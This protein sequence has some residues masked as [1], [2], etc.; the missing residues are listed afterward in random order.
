MRSRILIGALLLVGLSSAGVLANRATN[1]EWTIIN[2][3]DPVVV[4]DSLVMGPV[5]IVHDDLKMAQ[6][7]PC[8]TFYR[9]DPATGPG[10]AI[11]SFHCLPVQREAV[12]QTK[13][14]LAPSTQFY[15]C[16]RLVEYQI[17]GESEAHG[18]PEQ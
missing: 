14:T 3:P 11:V 8:T 12:E 1:K 2:F 18:I 5:L 16:K 4:K 15:G 17:G 9:F 10:E 13:L 6:G 7:Q